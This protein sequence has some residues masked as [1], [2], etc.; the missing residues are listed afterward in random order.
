MYE[1]LEIR[2]QSRTARD[3]VKT[4]FAGQ[5]YAVKALFRQE[6]HTLAVVYGHLRAGVQRQRGRHLTYGARHA[7]ILNDY[8]VCARTA[9]FADGGLEPRHFVL[10]DHGVQ[11][12][13]Y[14]H[15]ARVAI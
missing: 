3:F 7:K 14:P 4:H 10:P 12:N 6:F 8:A 9:D 13:V 2:P 11:R 15:A 5:H 1:Y